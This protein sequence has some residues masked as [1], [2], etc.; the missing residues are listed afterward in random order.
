MNLNIQRRFSIE[1][2]IKLFSYKPS[3]F[4]VSKLQFSQQFCVENQMFNQL[5]SYGIGR[6]DFVEYYNLS[7][8][9]TKWRRRVRKKKYGEMRIKR[10]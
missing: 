3:S 8:S 6:I 1:Y 7:F 5:N 2:Y 9:T 4:L 10:E